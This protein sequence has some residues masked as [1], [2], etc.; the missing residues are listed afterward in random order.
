MIFLVPPASSLYAA[1]I[2]VKA[3]SDKNKS[4]AATRP[5]DLH[6]LGYRKY[7]RFTS[8]LG[9]AEDKSDNV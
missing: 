8:I 7:S 1:T 3:G 2:A 4:F 6:L 5:A 9:S